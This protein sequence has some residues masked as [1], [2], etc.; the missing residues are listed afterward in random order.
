VPGPALHHMIADRL[1][2]AIGRGAGLG[3]TLSASEYK[4]LEALL[5]DARTHP[6]FFLGCQGPDFLF[7]NTKDVSPTIEA[8]VTAYYDVYDFI[9]G[10]KRDLLKLVPQPV[11]DALAALDEAKNEVVTS[12]ST[13]TELEELFGDMQAVVDALSS[14]LFEMVK[15]FVSEFNLY[16]L[17]AHPY[18]DGVPE[19]TKPPGFDVGAQRASG[20]NEWWWFDAMHYR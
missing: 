12:S 7:F 13:L 4:D 15:R 9:E 8:L 10:F 19:G 20:V 17:V 1:Q 18:R 5:S 14:A 2:V 11:L 6:Y 16:D 3:D